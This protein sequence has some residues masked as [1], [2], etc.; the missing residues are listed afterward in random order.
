M[1]LTQKIDGNTAHVSSPNTSSLQNEKMLLEHCRQ[2]GLK[3]KKIK[4]IHDQTGEKEKD[5]IRNLRNFSEEGIKAI[6]TS[7]G[8]RIENI[9]KK[10]IILYNSFIKGSGNVY[11]SE[12]PTITWNFYYLD[13]KDSS[14]QQAIDKKILE[15]LEYFRDL[16]GIPFLYLS[17]EQLISKCWP[18]DNYFT[19]DKEP[20]T[21]LSNLEKTSSDLITYGR[22]LRL[23]KLNNDD[24]TFKIRVKNYESNINSEQELRSILEELIEELPENINFYRKGEGK[25]ISAIGEK[26]VFIGSCLAKGKNTYVEAKTYPQ[27]NDNSLSEKYFNTFGS[28]IEKKYS[29]IISNLKNILGGDLSYFHFLGGLGNDL[30]TLIN[31]A[32][33]NIE[34]YKR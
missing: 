17:Y 33:D 31:T 14:I 21:S 29:L 22:E 15:Q 20:F 4:D 34:T 10:I 11:L 13:K 7:D 26:L 16:D 18:F 19:T 5:F 30:V 9:G 23:K 25:I 6:K 28:E 2:F 27:D 24:N 3:I 12:I 1:N 32:I 8:R